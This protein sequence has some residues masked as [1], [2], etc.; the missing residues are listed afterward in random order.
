MFDLID[1]LLIKFL[2]GLDGSSSADATDAEELDSISNSSVSSKLWSTNVYLV[3]LG[4]LQC[5]LLLLPSIPR[6]IFFLEKSVD[7]SGILDR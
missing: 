5:C 2:F 4:R 6:I 1:L 7:S 3:E